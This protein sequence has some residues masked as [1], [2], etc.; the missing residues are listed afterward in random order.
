[1]TENPRPVAKNASM[2]LVKLHGLISARV[3]K[4]LVPFPRS[5][6]AVC[7]TLM[8]L[9]WRNNVSVVADA[10]ESECD[11][12]NGGAA[13]GVRREGRVPECAPCFVSSRLAWSKLWWSLPQDRQR[14]LLH[15]ERDCS[16]ARQL[17]Q[18]LLM[19]T[20]RRRFSGLRLRKR[21][22]FCSEWT[23]RQT[24]QRC[25]PAPRGLWCLG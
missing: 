5:T 18:Y 9:R 21:W 15:N 8:L 23:P 11:A 20:A 4:D 7:S 10:V 16:W 24:R 22:H 6:S 19:G 12:P 3:S 1:M 25:D 17:R 13:D 14:S 2:R